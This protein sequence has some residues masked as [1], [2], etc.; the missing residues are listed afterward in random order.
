MMKTKTK[1]KPKA[2]VAQAVTAEPG[3]HSAGD[4]A[5]LYLKKGASGAGAWIYRFHHDGKSQVMGL[6]LSR[7]GDARRSDEASE[8]A[9]RPARRGD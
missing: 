8:R 1:T 5:G 9:P 6:G 4:S 2:A 3:I 7:Q